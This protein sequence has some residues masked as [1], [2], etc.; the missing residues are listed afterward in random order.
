MDLQPVAK[1]ARRRVIHSSNSSDS[2]VFKYVEPTRARLSRS[3]VLCTHCD[4]YVA[5]VRAREHF[6]TYWIPLDPKKPNES[7]M[8]S[9]VFKD[10]L[11]LKVS[12][13]KDKPYVI[14]GIY[15]YT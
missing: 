4:E 6:D 3:E 1:R 2:Y 5:R 7:D 13:H 11:P 15:I 14:L 9:Y 8:W 10:Y 12:E